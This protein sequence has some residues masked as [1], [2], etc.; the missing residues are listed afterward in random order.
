VSDA[1]QPYAQEVQQRREAILRQMEQI[2]AS[3]LFK[4][5]KRCGPLLRYAVLETLDGRGEH[6]KERAIGADVFGRKLNYDT[7]VDPIVRTTA[8]E[9]RKRIA[10]YYHEYGQTATV[11]IDLSSGS[12]VPEFRFADPAEPAPL[13]IAASASEWGPPQAAAA[14]EPAHREEAAPLLLQETK[15]PDRKF[16]GIWVVALL[17]VF[18]VGIWLAWGPMQRAQDPLER[19]WEPFWQANSVTFAMGGGIFADPDPSPGHQPQSAQEALSADQVGFVDAA[20]MLEVARLFRSRGKEINLRR[21][22]TLTLEEIRKGPVVLIGSNNPWTTRLMSSLRFHIEYPAPYSIALRDREKPTEKLF[23]ADLS[24]TPAAGHTQSYAIISRF[25]DRL[26]EHPVII[27]AGLGKE[28]TI[29]A[30]EFATQAKYLALL[31]QRAPKGWTK[32]NLQIVISAE[33][34]NGNSGPP[35]IVAIHSW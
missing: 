1:I 13:R 11:R 12:Y 16:R 5:S 19:F 4:H 8:S 29:A 34:I 3:R 33:V 31:D 25:V 30:G 28:G 10:Q 32:G 23:S 22:G 15:A 18:G 9:V 7:S 2:L 17:A 20:A 21:G 26:T 14:P 6:L 24:A 27:L 35:V